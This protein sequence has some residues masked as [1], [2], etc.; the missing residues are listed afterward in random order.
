MPRCLIA[1]GSNLGD[2][3]QFLEEALRRL[4]AI[5]RIQ[6][7]KRSAWRETRSV[8]GPGGQVSYLN[9]AAVLETSLGPH[10]LL[11]MMHD[12][13]RD[14]G[15]RRGRRWDART[16]DLDLLLYDEST[17]S[18][19]SLEVPHPRMA[20]RR[21]VLEPAAEIAGEM[22]HPGIGWTIA[23]LLEHLDAARPYV[24]I[25]GPIGAGKTLL[26][27]RWCRIQ[28]ARFVP[29]SL[30]ESKLEAFYADPA[31]K[32][33]A[34]ELDFLEMRRRLLSTAS[35]GDQAWSENRLAASDFWF[36]QSA[37]F[38][39]V[40]LAADE[41]AA[42]ER[43][44]E[45]LKRAVVRPKLLVLLDA[46]AESLLAR[47]RRRGRRGE[48]SLTLER[49]ERLRQSILRQVALPDVGPVLKL[50]SSSAED[51]IAEVTAAVE[52]ME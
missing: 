23:R 5:R 18:T 21:F 24:A 16:I 45:E 44:F 1:L 15:R 9:G 11:Q 27:E 13:E 26:A 37:A 51:A 32:G 19:P 47:I 29:E 52:A 12:I 6:V 3:R 10:E 40:W 41:F 28:A 34:T 20:W 8:G 31:G 33:W 7:E 43:R 36:D 39:R 22:R 17:I 4:A 30:E 35:D 42:F 48:D 46:P 14:L 50:I 25:G 38:A 2:R 49:L